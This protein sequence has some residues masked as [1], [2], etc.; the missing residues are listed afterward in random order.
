MGNRVSQHSHSFG[1]TDKATSRS[2]FADVRTAP[3]GGLSTVLSIEYGLASMVKCKKSHELNVLKPSLIMCRIL[4]TPNDIET[5]FRD[6]HTHL[7]ANANDSGHYMY[8]LLGI[9]LGLVSGQ[10]WRSLRKETEAPFTRTATTTYV[11]SVLAHS[12]QHVASLCDTKPDK[13]Q[14]RPYA[15]LRVYPFLALADILYG[16]LTPSLKVKLLEIIPGRDSVFSHM[17]M[18]GVTRYSWA[19]YL[20]LK[21]NREMRQFKQAWGRW[22]DDAYIQALSRDEKGERAPIVQ[23]YDAITKGRISR[24]ALLQTLDEMLFANLDVSIGALAWSFVFI[25]AYPHVQARLLSELKSTLLDPKSTETYLM[26]QSNYLHHILLEGGR[27]R[28]VA[29]FSVAQACPTRRQV[30]IF[31][32]PAGSKFVVDA[33]ALNVRDPLWGPDNTTFRPERWAE[34]GVKRAKDIRYCYWRFGFGPRVC[35]GKYVVDLIMKALIVEVVRDWMV[36][37]EDEKGVE[38][39]WKEDTWTLPPELRIACVKRNE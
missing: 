13:W 8:Q 5:V 30:G 34:G 22:N 38:W 15:D 26:S 18:G 1:Q 17:M 24:E 37:L 36:K 2:I 23:M 7:K 25:A 19:K 32:L 39:E 11:E 6:S 31:D 20:P 4:T 29:A 21:A 9:C 12:K 14:L 27:L 10:E 16:T 33:H 3:N 28:P 35:L